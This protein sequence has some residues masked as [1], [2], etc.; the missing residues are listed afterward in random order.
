MLISITN[1]AY[2]KK[3]NTIVDAGTCLL[4]GPTVFANELNWP[5]VSSALVLARCV[6]SVGVCS[7][8]VCSVGMCSD[9]VQG[10]IPSLPDAP[11]LMVPY[12]T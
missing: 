1:T 4:A 2:C 12:E 7:V 8:V 3:C 10:E 11:G 6:G 9:A 5:S